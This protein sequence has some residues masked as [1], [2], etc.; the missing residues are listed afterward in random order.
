MT[1]VDDRHLAAGVRGTFCDGQAEE[2]RTHDEEIHGAVSFHARARRRIDIGEATGRRRVLSIVMSTDLPAYE[3][4]V[5]V[6]VPVYNAVAHLGPC[7]ASILAQTHRELD[8]ILVDDGSTDGSGALCDEI[9]ESDPRVRVIHQNNGGIG[10]AQNAGLDAAAGEFITF[11]DN[12]DL[13]SPHLVERLLTILLDA[14]ADMSCCRWWNVGASAATAALEQHRDDPP[15]TAITFDDPGHSYQNV[16]SVALRRLT[17]QE[18]RYFSE[19][20]WGKLYRASLFD[21]VR[22]PAGRFAQDVAIAMDLYLRMRRVASCSDRLY[23]WLQ[24]GD[25]VSHSLRS[26]SYYHDIVQA[27]ARSF[28]TALA[29][30][31]LPARAFY[32]LTALQF[33]HRAVQT[34]ADAERY[35]ADRALVQSLKSRLTLIQRAG[36]M[37]ML[38]LRRAEVFVYDRTIHRRS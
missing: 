1:T 5:S 37:G 15:G 31:I 14:D 36:C 27:H 11:C 21:G 30:G 28:E 6:I 2:A 24:R 19:A 18:L 23:F 38:L 8:V 25:S 9:A 35:R 16:F 22:F 32:G 26:A 34:P 13:M 17:K 12:D 29:K 20:N 7:I 3:R 33:E 4:T 10:S